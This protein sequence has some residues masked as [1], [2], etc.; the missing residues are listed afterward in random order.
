MYTGRFAPSPTGSLHFGSLVTAV[1]SYLHARQRRG[2]WLVRIEDLDTPR[3]IKGADQSILT[4]L[5]RFGMDWDGDII[6]QSQRQQAYQDALN[7]LISQ[8]LIYPCTC[9]RQR[10][11]G[12]V[13]DGYCKHH[14]VSP[15]QPYALRI[16]INTPFLQFFD[17]LQGEIRHNMLT[18][19]G[20]FIVKRKDGL[21][22]YQLAVVV[23]DAEQGITD[24]VRGCDLLETTTRQLYLQQVLNLPHPNYTHLPIIVNAQGL[25]LSKQ[26][27]APIIDDQPVLPLLHHA[28]TLLGQSPPAD[29]IHENI[30]AFWD[31][32]IKN[33]SITHVP[34]Q[35]NLQPLTVAL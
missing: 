33:W 13:Y 20:D 30:Q 29:L 4:T 8:Q 14:P 19:I 5:R 11:K 21:F 27:H 16:K 3:I 10:L 22:A 15:N 6:Y 31:W 18:E 26:N 17:C 2:R 23:D 9:T 35:M 25:K 12:K 1:G 28:L 24:V 7:M 34:L 32:A